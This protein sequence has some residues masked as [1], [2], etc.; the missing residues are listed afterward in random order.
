MTRP[1]ILALALAGLGLAAPS[2]AQD[3]MYDACRSDDLVCR[4]DRLERTVV[5]LTERLAAYE[6]TPFAPAVT[7]RSID[8]PVSSSCSGAGCSTVAAQTCRSAGFPRGV[9]AEFSNSGGFTVMVRVTC[10]D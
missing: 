2:A 7:P 10:M 9:P 6:R 3:A 8:V 4:V 1:L 5:Q